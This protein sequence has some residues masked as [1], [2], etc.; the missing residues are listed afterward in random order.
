[1]YGKHGKCYG[2]L[3]K[4]FSRYGISEEQIVFLNYFEDDRD[5]AIV[6]IESAD[7]LYFLGGVPDRMMERIHTLGIA[8]ALLAHNGV[9]MGYSA[10]ALVQLREYHVSP[11]R[12]YPTFGYYQGLSYLDEFYLEVH[13]EGCP[14]Q[15]AAIQRVLRERGK[16]VYA[17]TYKSSGIIVDSGRI[18]TIGNVY[19]FE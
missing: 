17:T 3:V 4:P 12:D 1:M 13:Y 7:I 2:S 8:D 14:E 18:A 9:V 16:K 19:L 11:D 10:G 5:D 6:K 15:D